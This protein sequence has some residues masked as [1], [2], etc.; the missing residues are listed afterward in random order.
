MSTWAF[1]DKSLH[2]GDSKL[3]P[4]FWYVL[5]DEKELRCLLST[6]AGV[7]PEEKTRERRREVKKTGMEGGGK[8]KKEKG[9]WKM[10]NAK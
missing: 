1:C 5:Q 4:C 6:A 10:E 8:R 3:E 9:K 7:V 2:H